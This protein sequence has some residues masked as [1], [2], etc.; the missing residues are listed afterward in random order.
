MYWHRRLDERRDVFLGYCSSSI[1][2]AE[3]VK[4]LLVDY[5]VTVLD[6]R[7]D[8]APGSSILQQIEHAAARCGSGIFLFT[9]DDDLVNPLT[10]GHAAPRDN[11]V[12]EAGYFISAKGKDRVLILREEGAKMPADLGGDI[13]GSFADRSELYSIADTLR[14]FVDAA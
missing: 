7:T 6:W 1:V 11:V 12:F 9:K 14:R 2:A 4:G 5:G 13:Y 3:Q 10:D 8:F